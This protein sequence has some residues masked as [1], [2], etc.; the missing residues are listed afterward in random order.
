MCDCEDVHTH[1]YREERRVA[2]KEYQCGECKNA[3]PAGAR[4]VYWV[5][6]WDDAWR[7]SNF[8]TFRMCVPCAADWEQVT[9]AQYAATGQSCICYGE[10]GKAVAQAVELGYLP[11]DDPLAQKWLSDLFAEHSAR[12]YRALEAR[13]QLSLAFT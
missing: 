11:E 9:D 8:S 7:D 4:H 10:L 13:G 3:I 2:R 5:G 12:E 6:K 1:F